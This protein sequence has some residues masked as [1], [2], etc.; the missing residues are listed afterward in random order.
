MNKNSSFVNKNIRI[1]NKIGSKIKKTRED[2]GITQDLM[3]Y[4]LEMS[5]ANYGRLEK[6]DARLNVPKLNKIAEVLEVNISF[7]FNE[8]SANI[9]HQNTGD[10]AQAQNQT[11]YNAD[12]EH[13]ATLKEEITFLRNM[14][15]K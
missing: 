11:I 7:L 5:Q 15:K 9:I 8:K 4:H 2:K 14:L 13:I 1:M 6:D 12:K 10:N 3:A